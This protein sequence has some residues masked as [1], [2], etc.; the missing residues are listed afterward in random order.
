MENEIQNA[1]ES[2]N[3]ALEV[4]KGLMSAQN[5]AIFYGLIIFLIGAIISLFVYRRNS[6]EVLKNILDIIKYATA[7]IVGGCIL[8]SPNDFGSYIFLKITICIYVVINVF[9]ILMHKAVTHKN[10]KK[11]NEEE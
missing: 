2:V 4:F 8:K 5:S 10:E 7:I 3:N 6:D 11:D 9:V 1:I